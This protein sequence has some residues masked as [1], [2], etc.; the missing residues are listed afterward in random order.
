MH[1]Y[2]TRGSVPVFALQGPVDS[3]TVTELKRRV[4]AALADGH[5]LIVIDLLA[6][7][8]MGPQIPS[9]LGAALRTVNDGARLAIIGADPRVQ[10]ALEL[11]GIDGLELHATINAALDPAPPDQTGQ[12]SLQQAE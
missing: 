10:T 1:I 8:A 9:E 12:D 5:R 11:C 4:G 3:N 2:L 6:T 7:P